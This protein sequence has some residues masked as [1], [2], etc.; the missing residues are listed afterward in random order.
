MKTLERDQSPRREYVGGDYISISIHMKAR[1]SE[2][3]VVLS[4]K[5]I[6]HI[7]LQRMHRRRSERLDA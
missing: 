1:T 2:K 7:L 4:G 5:C 6:L 3:H